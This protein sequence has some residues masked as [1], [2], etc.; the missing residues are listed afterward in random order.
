[1][2]GDKLKQLR[3]EISILISKETNESPALENLRDALTHLD[4]AQH[5]LESSPVIFRVRPQVVVKVK[6]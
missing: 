5:N 6:P 1:M 3:R 2:D 4:C